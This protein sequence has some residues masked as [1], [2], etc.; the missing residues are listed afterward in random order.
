MRTLQVKESETAAEQLK[1]E[2][3]Q[4]NDQYLEEKFKKRVDDIKEE[5]SH[6]TGDIEHLEQMEKALMETLS[7]TTQKRDE[8]M[9]IIRTINS[10]VGKKWRIE[11][12]W[13]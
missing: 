6:V 7:R 12:L 5:K 13:E 11:I 3:E 9:S 10:T 4:L 2:K 1:R 8:K